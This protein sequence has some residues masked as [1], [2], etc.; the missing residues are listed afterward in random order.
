MPVE[1]KRLFGKPTGG[2][3]KRNMVGILIYMAAEF[4]RTDI[5]TEKS[6]V[7]GFAVFIKRS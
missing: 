2:F 5:H 4:L 7:Y 3:N 1:N 6:D